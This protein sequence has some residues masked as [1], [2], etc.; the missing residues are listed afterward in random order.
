VSI[1]IETLIFCDGAERGWPCPED[2]PYA[3]GDARGERASAQRATA[4]T[5]GWRTVGGVLD[6]CPECAKRLRRVST[7]GQRKEQ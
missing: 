5:D 6:Y 1:V 3:S 7:S 2:G 4:R